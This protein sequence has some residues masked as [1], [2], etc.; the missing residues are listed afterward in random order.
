MQDADENEKLIIQL[1]Y[2]SQRKIS[3]TESSSTSFLHEKKHF[4][5]TVA[6]CAVA[7]SILIYYF[8]KFARTDETQHGSTSDDHYDIM[9]TLQEKINPRFIEEN[10]KTLTEK[11]HVAG[12]YQDEVVLVD[13]IRKKW[14]AILDD[15]EVFAYNVTL[16]YPNETDSNYVTLTNPDGTDLFKSHPHEMP[17]TPSEEAGHVIEGFNSYSPAGDV[18]GNLYY[19]NY[20]QVSDFEYLQSL[21]VDLTGSVCLARYGKVYRGDKALLASTFNCSGLVLYSDP[22]DYA[23]YSQGSWTPDIADQ[24]TFPDTWWLPKDGFQRGSLY[25]NGDPS[26]P[27]YPSLDFIY[28]EK[29]E[30]NKR[31]PQVC[32]SSH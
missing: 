24:Q 16:S 28:R 14:N 17:L 32:N 31:F 29:L 1:G 13:F 6:V 22:A 19:V 12:S 3:A 20:A 25:I 5:Y 26:T 2:S 30:N 9:L 23:G 11:P 10:L 7:V 15:V 27:N 4:A 18:T 21:S 8:G